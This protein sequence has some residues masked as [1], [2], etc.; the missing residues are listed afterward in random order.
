MAQEGPLNVSELPDYGDDT[1]T[2]VVGKAKMK[3]GDKCTDKALAAGTS[4]EEPD[5]DYD[6]KEPSFGY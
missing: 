3:T 1:N 4:P 2:T 5:D 6:I